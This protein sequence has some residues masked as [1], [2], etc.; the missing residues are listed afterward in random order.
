MASSYVAGLVTGIGA[1][2]LTPTPAGVSP[3]P[4]PNDA[5]YPYVTVQQVLGEEVTC[6]EGLS[7][8]CGTVMQINCWSKSYEQAFAMRAAIQAYLATLTGT[9]GATG[10]K[11]ERVTDFKTQELYH[12][13]P[14]LHQLILR[15]DVWWTT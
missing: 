3:V 13:D 10:T 9:I 6:M 5:A 11:V 4:V 1:A 7:N 12:P 2:G 15:A 14:E 8:L